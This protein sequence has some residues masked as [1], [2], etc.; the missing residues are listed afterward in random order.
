VLTHARP[1]NEKLRIILQAAQKEAWAI[2]KG[3]APDNEAQATP[4]D[5]PQGVSKPKPNDMVSVMMPEEMARV[6]EER[7]LGTNTA[8]RTYLAGPV[9]FSEDDLP[10]YFIGIDPESIS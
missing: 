3:M 1:V 6:F 8:G 4:D 9:I 5:F 2:L 7:C 10:S